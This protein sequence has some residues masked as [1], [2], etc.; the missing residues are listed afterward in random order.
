M[1]R[2]CNGDEQEG[3]SILTFAAWKLAWSFACRGL[4]PGHLLEW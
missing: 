2:G 3:F 1:E 4:S